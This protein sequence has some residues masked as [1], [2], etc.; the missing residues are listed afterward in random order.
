MRVESEGQGVRFEWGGEPDAVVAVGLSGARETNWERLAL[1]HEVIR[2]QRAAGV[3][4]TDLEL[5]ERFT[6]GRRLLLWRGQFEDWRTAGLA[7][8]VLCRAVG[9]DD[10]EVEL[11]VRP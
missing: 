11:E 4:W 8:A 1:L 6:A 3:E 2:S 10:P 7:F 9:L 5:R